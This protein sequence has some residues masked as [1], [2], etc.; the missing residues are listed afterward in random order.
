MNRALR[1]AVNDALN[2]LDWNLISEFCSE[3]TDKI[4]PTEMKKIMKGAI[5]TAV[6]DMIDENI[7][8]ISIAYFTITIKGDES[9]HIVSILFTP[10]KSI[11]REN[12]DTGPVLKTEI[13]TL[14]ELLKDA[15]KDENYEL[16]ATLRDRINKLKK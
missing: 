1:K 3:P 2:G 16:A 13:Y 10:T 8:E 9:K 12:P 4:K 14:E 5:F 7:D 6:Q 15:V 11:G